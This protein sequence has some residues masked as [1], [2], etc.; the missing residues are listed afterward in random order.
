MVRCCQN[1]RN[2][3]S[4]LVVFGLATSQSNGC[5]QAA[6]A[7]ITPDSTLGA[8]QSVVV[9]NVSFNN[10]MGD[11]IDGGAIR[12][13]NLFHSFLDFNIASGRAAYFTNPSGVSNIFS[14][15]TGTSISNIQGTLGVLGTA[16]LFLINPNGIL[17]GP[18]ASLDLRG[19]FVGSTA[20][21]IQF[22]DGTRYSARD[23][24][25][26]PLLTVSL[27]IGL[28]FGDNPG[29]IIQRS[30]AI[31]PI[32]PNFAGEPGGLEVDPGETLA[33]IGGEILL[34]GG[35]ITAP[36]GR[37]E[38]G[39]VGS[40]ALVSLQP[41][42]Q[43]WSF[44]YGGV[45]AFRDIQ[46]TQRQEQTSLITSV[47]DVSSSLTLGQPL[48]SGEIQLQGQHIKINEGTEIIAANLSDQPANSLLING[49]QS[50]EL[51]GS[52]GGGSMIVLA[53]GAGPGGNLI[54]NT[55]SLTVR[56][57]SQ[58]TTTTLGSGRGGNLIINAPAQVEITGGTRNQS[59]QLLLS[60]LFAG[61][62]GS[63]D[64]GSIT[65]NTPRLSILDGG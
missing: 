38:L 52:Q 24:Q 58:I 13:G 62:A 28:Q 25:V 48:P 61:T 47:I 50:V 23:P 49:S 17:F 51:S 15:V 57:G 54:I 29:A 11:R 44:S 32:S 63:G 30:Q 14:R 22:A 19:S 7:Q 16:N 26:S 9:P 35:N 10:Q 41:E 60:T 45:S 36:S 55:P 12:G 59:G 42:A 5:I 40:N 20:S 39:S 1:P 3:I 37:V 53:L 46:I 8:E 6:S 4:C 2:F 33:L 31:N 21:Q 64:A 56:D 18:R 27:P 34:E 43:G 65:I